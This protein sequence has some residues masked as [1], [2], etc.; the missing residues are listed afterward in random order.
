MRHIKAP[1]IVGGSAPNRAL[2]T[3]G[4]SPDG[5]CAGT[6]AWAGTGVLGGGAGGKGGTAGIS[7]VGGPGLVAFGAGGGGTGIAAGGRGGGG[8]PGESSIESC[9]QARPGSSVRPSA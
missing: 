3:S 9:A 2:T 7:A 6:T 1:L 8:P 5:C 4:T